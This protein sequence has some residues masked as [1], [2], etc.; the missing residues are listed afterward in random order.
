M[1]LSRVVEN[2]TDNAFETRTSEVLGLSRERNKPQKV[3][4]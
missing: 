1:C 3:V 2:S 4:K